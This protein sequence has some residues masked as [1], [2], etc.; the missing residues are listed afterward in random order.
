MTN[1]LATVQEALRESPFDALILVPGPNYYYVTGVP[2][3]ASE[4]LN[5]LVVPKVGEPAALTPLLEAPYLQ[6][7]DITVYE[8]RDGEGPG[9]ALERL[10]RDMKLANAGVGVEYGTMR[11]GEAERLR[12]A[13]P[14]IRFGRAEEF[15]VEMRSVKDEEELSAIRRAIAVTEE[16]L[17]RTVGEIRPGQAEREVAARLQVNLLNAGADQMAFGPLVVSGPRSAEA[18]AGPGDRVLQAGDA[19]I[20]DCGAT[21][22]HYSGDI[23]RCLAIEPVPEEILNIH[24][25]CLRANEAGRDAVR[26]RATGHEVDTAT[27][28]VIEEAGYGEYFV[29][30]TGHGLGLEIH[31]PPDMV[32][33][34]HRPL[35]PGNVFTIEPGIYLPGLGGVRIEDNIA[36]TRTGGDSMTTY[37]RELIRVVG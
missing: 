34:N 10:V 13:A 27:R 23:T 14:E 8:W 25:I 19:I 30:R 32:Q 36:V 3:H 33:G 4:R 11:Y 1:R 20:I 15:L 37:P 21:V 28:T 2:L 29:H 9:D 12:T 24:R 5:L 7:L 26:P 16:G 22:E 35:Q 31:E 17:R 18:H 6:P